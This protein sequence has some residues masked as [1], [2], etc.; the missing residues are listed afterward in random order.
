[1]EIGEVLTKRKFQF[2]ILEIATTYPNRFNKFNTL[3]KPYSPGDIERRIDRELTVSERNLAARAFDNLVARELLQSDYADM[4]NPENWVTLTDLGRRVLERQA[5]DPLDE[6]LQALSPKLIELR[7]GMWEGL[8]SKRTNS[9]QQA[10][11]SAR[12]LITQTLK[13]G[14]PNI[15]EDAENQRR[16]RAR[17]IFKQKAT[18]FSK[19]DFEAVD[20]GIQ[21]LLKRDD[22]LNA[23]VHARG[24]LDADKVGSMIAQT[25]LLL[26]D[27]LL[28]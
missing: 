14:A 5:L 20:A 28:P 7:D 13:I 18:T 9:L 2:L 12:E 4:V 22:Q 24:E 1:M 17:Y 8:A 27:L 19:S 26:K 21:Y 23:A 3:G 16:E 10:A 6:A 25:E 15:S 11:N